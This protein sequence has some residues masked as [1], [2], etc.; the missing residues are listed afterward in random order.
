MTSIQRDEE[1]MRFEKRQIS[2]SRF[3]FMLLALAWSS[4]QSASA[5]IEVVGTDATLDVATWNIEWF[6]ASYNGPS[7]DAVQ[8][9][10]VADIVLG[11]G[12][13]LWAVQ[14]IASIPRTEELLSL[15]PDK[16]DMILAESGQQRLG[17]LYDS[18]VLSLRS[19]AHILTDFNRAFATR[20]PLKAEF[21][22]QLPDTSFIVTVI[23]VH[24]KAFSDAD[25]YARRVEA[26][27]RVKNHIDFT[28]LS[29]QPVLFMGDFNDKLQSSTHAGLT[30]PYA[31]FVND[32]Q[33]YRMLTLP[34]E[35][36]GIG[37]YLGGSTID[38]IVVTD[39][40]ADLWV[41]GSTQVLTRLVTVNGYA[42]RT[43]DHLPVVA[44][45]GRV[46]GT[47][48][49]EIPV[50][51]NR[52]LSLSLYPNPAS[53]R[54]NVAWDETSNGSVRVELID[55]MGRV[56]QST[57]TTVSDFNI[58]LTSFSPGL[59][60]VRVQKGETVTSKVFIRR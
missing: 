29:S 15:L 35:Q 38:H 40:M 6:G 20:P 4:M 28:S 23:N 42:V 56:V 54:L 18:D 52:N 55:L 32:P 26:A 16:W 21:E 3:I 10:N 58:D 17:Y 36:A 45:F 34:I 25:S 24:M 51:S 53:D 43:S 13:D 60:L 57:S 27:Q 9:Q 2:Q 8:V 49:E 59:Y 33:D 19:R 14:E 41:D 50:H 30:S 7:D 31:P 11:T 44:S 12:I 48:V 39:E 5:Q 1:G 22:V 37:T 47:D 46:T